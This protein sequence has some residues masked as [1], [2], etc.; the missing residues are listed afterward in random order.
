[1]RPSN[2]SG[3]SK[4]AQIKHKKSL[5]DAKRSQVF[6][7]LTHTITLAA[8][9]KGTDPA[10]NP[11]LRTAIEK[12]Q[13]ANM[14]KDT[15]DRALHK[16]ASGEQFSRVL[17]EAYG[18]GG[19]AFLVEGIT[20]N[21]NRTF[22]E[23]RKII[24]SREGKMT[25]GGALWAF[26]KKGDGWEPTTTIPVDAATKKKITELVEALREHEDIQSVYSNSA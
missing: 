17:Y 13:Q 16:A 22:A 25:P 3:H 9:E 8:R 19:V 2:M 15:I 4:W 21:N 23:I 6:S 24:E 14:S 1:M 20:D 12:A 7:R 26:A 10:M 11:S 18:P 5:V